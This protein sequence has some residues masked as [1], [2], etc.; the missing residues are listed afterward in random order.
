MVG[1]L[2]TA[3]GMRLIDRLNARHDARIATNHCSDP[4]RPSAVHRTAATQA[5]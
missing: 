1:A 5:V 2:L 3:L 4:S